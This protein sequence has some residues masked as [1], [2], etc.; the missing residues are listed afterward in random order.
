MMWPIH[1]S[2]KGNEKV[3]ESISCIPKE[4]IGL[5]TFYKLMIFIIS[6]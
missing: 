6:D 3:N 1:S 5:L 4:L 2:E